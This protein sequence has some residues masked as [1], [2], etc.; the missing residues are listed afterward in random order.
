MRKKEKRKS[1]SAHAFKIP[2][3]RFWGQSVCDGEFFDPKNY[4]NGA[5]TSFTG[6]FQAALAAA[7]YDSTRVYNKITLNFGIGTQKLKIF[8]RSL[9]ILEDATTQICAPS[10]RFN[11]DKRIKLECRACFNIFTNILSNGCSSMKHSR[12]ETVW[13]NSNVCK[14]SFSSSFKCVLIDC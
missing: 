3:W 4:G 14:F 2:H 10:Q 1:Q 11:C 6:H 12:M 13:I 5:I 9:L 8:G 7:G